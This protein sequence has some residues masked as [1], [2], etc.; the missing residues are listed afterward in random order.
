MAYARLLF[1]IIIALLLAGPAFAEPVSVNRGTGLGYVFNHNGNCFLVLPEHVHGRQT[2]LS[3]ATTTP[4][5]IGEASLVQTWAPALDLSLFVVSGLQKGCND[6]FA[7]LPRDL[8]PLLDGGD[9]A[10]LVRVDAGG[11]ELRD[12]MAIVAVDYALLSARLLTEDRASEIYQGSSGAILRMGDTVVGMAV[13][14]PDVSHATILRMDEIV[15]QISRKVTPY[16]AG[17]EVAPAPSA[18][19]APGQCGPGT[20]AI[21][22]VTCSI[23]PLTPDLA[24]SSLMGPGAGLAAFP[25]GARPRLVIDLAVDEPVPLGQVSLAANVEEGLYAVPQNVIVEV[26][27]AASTPRWQRFGGADMSPLGVLNISN[28]ALPYA[29]QIAITIGSSWDI[30]LP[31]ALTC[32]AL[33]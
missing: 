4:S 27:A 23:E 5:S 33:R 9:E 3:V 15:A 6:R 16:A 12:E 2:R 29:R 32:I 19:S 8:A 20:I 17:G 31:T 13:Q 22:A 11:S 21:A 24:C 18:S 7:D 1:Q 30:D 25:P 28:G 14:S 10:V 26:S